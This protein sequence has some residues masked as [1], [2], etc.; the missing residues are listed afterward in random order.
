MCDLTKEVTSVS[1]TFCVCDQDIDVCV[2]R[3]I[4]VFET[5]QEA[6]FARTDKDLV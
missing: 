6:F 1:K 2:T 5:G 3:L 4:S